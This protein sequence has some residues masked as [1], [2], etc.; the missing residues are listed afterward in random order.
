LITSRSSFFNTPVLTMT[1]F[2]DHDQDINQVDIPSFS[3]G[4]SRIN[5]L[6]LCIGAQKSAT[7]WLAANLR[8]DERFSKSP[9]GKEIHYFDYLYNNSPHLNN[10]RAHFLLKLCQKESDRL[11]PLLSAWLTRKNK[12]IENVIKKMTGNDKLLARRFYLLI[13]ELNDE[14]YSELLRVGKNQEIALDV[15]PDYAV[16][17]QRG[18]EHVKN[19]ANDVKI[20]FIL[21]DPVYRAWSAILQRNKK[22]PN[23]IPGF[24]SDKGSDIN[25]LFK[26]TS[27][28]PDIGARNN[29]LSNLDNLKSA[30][31]LDGRV[32]IKFYEDVQFE[33]ESF[34]KD[35]Y[36]FLNIPIPSMA[37]FSETLKAKI[38]ETPKAN[39]PVEL[40]HRLKSHYS[41]MVREI[42]DQYIKVPDS[43][44]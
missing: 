33:P 6:F 26:E 41:K 16:I 2:T 29:Y 34:M 5:K 44:L 38:H 42:N 13:S 39:I 31:L 7:S 23:G 32:L 22:H 15:T 25:Y 27:S 11:K 40:E 14:W 17:G 1:F 9:F 28:G 37:T 4:S 24:I 35:I 20:L 10:W 12:N 21:R 19:I 30:G 18:F 36:R 43:W 3:L 8:K